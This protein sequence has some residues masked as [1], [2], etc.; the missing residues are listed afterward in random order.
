MS[1]IAFDGQAVSMRRRSD[2]ATRVRQ[3]LVLVGLIVLAVSPMVD[4]V[5]W[6]T[7]HPSTAGNVL[8]WVRGTQGTDSWYPMATAMEFFHA[9]PNGR[10][11]EQLFFIDKIKFQYPPS[12]LLIHQALWSYGIVPSD[13]ALNRINW[14]L[15]IVQVIATG[16]FGFTLARRST[17]YTR[18][19]WTIAAICAVGTL[20]FYPLINAY[21]QGQAQVWINTAFALTALAWFIDRK[22]LAGVLIGF[23]CLVKPQFAL[24]LLWGVLRR[25]WRFV[26][27]WA[28]VVV[29]G[30]VLAVAVFGLQNHLDYM[31]VLRALSRT[32]EAYI[33]N[34]SFNGFLNRLL[35]I[36]DPGN[37]IIVTDVDPNACTLLSIRL[38]SKLPPFDSTVYGGTLLTSAAMIGMSLLLRRREDAGASKLLDFLGAA[39][40]FTMASP[41]AWIHHY[42]I[43]PTIYVGALFVILTGDA[44]RRRWLALA[45]IAISYLMTAHWLDGSPTFFGALLLFCV[46]Y[47]RRLR[48]SRATKRLS[49][50][51]YRP[52]HTG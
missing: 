52:T 36:S 2:H 42:G 8:A 7:H 28:A 16:A 44:S 5:I 23:V 24:Y 47:E 11:Y 18:Y 1:H 34:Q 3:T 25:E 6:L 29:P 12:S 27:G 15:I 45:A 4:L 17:D 31:S 46:L 21:N 10:V 35:E 13:A 19:R 26:M 30:F 49:P 50:P 20:L 14:W 48:D 37:A 43:L 51:W 32:G 9:H 22:G 33:D 41:V 38:N 39:L 40:T